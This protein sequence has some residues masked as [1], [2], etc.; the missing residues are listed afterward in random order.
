MY[1]GANLAKRNLHLVSVLEEFWWLGRKPTPPGVPVRTTVPACNVWPL[2]RN[3]MI[4]GMSKSNSDVLLCCR[5]SPLTLVSRDR[6]CGL[7]I[8]CDLSVGQSS[9]VVDTYVAR[10]NTRPQGHKTIEALAIGHLWGRKCSNKIGIHLPLPGISRY[11]FHDPKRLL[12]LTWRIHRRRTCSR[13]HIPMLLLLSR[14]WHP[15]R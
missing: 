2:V 3:S 6:L 4:A 1:E 8:T 14:S 7:L 11:Q 15:F 5:T 13:A 12:R 9:V 10:D